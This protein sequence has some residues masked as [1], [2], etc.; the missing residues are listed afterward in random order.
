MDTIQAAHAG[1]RR[2]WFV[3]DARWLNAARPAPTVLSRDSFG[4]LG[5]ADRAR[6]NWYF[7]H[8]NALY[9]PPQLAVGSVRP[10]AGSESLVGWLFARSDSTESKVHEPGTD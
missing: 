8:L 6:A 1:G 5:Q 2:I 9:G 10:T 7:R 4:G 3:T